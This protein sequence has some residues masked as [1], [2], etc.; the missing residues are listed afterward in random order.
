MKI[1]GII[2]LNESMYEEITFK[3]SGINVHDLEFLDGSSPDDQI[4]QTFINIIN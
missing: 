1:K 4:V 3:N 2:R